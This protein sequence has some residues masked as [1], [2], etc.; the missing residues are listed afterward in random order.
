MNITYTEE[1]NF[2]EAAIQ[3]LFLSVGWVSGQ[4]PSRLNKALQNSSTVLTAWDDH[5]LVG[6]VRVLDDSEMVAFIHYVL[7][8]PNYQGMKIAGTMI[9]MIKEKYKNYLYIEIM[10]EERKNAAFYEKFGF[11]I[12]EDGVAMQLSNFQ[13]K[14]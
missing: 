1:K 6:L 13:N 11:K 14:C 5:K 7:V 9:E 4:F 12:M 3:E 8:N 2:T 10:P